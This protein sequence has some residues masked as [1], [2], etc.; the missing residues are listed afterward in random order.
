MKSLFSPKNPPIAIG[1]HPT[2]GAL[3]GWSHRFR[4][5]Q[6]VLCVNSTRKSLF[7]NESGLSMGRQLFGNGIPTSVSLLNSVAS[8][9]KLRS[10]LMKRIA[11]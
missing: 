9:V 11:A 8:E 4:Y 3:S 1:D 2:G 6:E 10:C 7:Y 5:Y